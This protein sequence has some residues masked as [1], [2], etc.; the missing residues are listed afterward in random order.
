MFS[1]ILQCVI[2][3]FLYHIYI[4]ACGTPTCTYPPGS[5][6]CKT[7]NYT[8]VDCTHRQ[9]TCI[10]SLEQSPVQIESLD[11]SWNQISFVPDH[12]F[13]GLI[14]LL[15]LN[16][17][18]NNISTINSQTFSG[19]SKLRHLDLSDNTVTVVSGSPFQDLVS[20][21]KLILRYGETDGQLITATS[22]AGLENLQSLHITIYKLKNDL[23]APFAELQSLSDLYILEALLL[24]TEYC[25]TIDFTGLGNLKNLTLDA[26]A[27]FDICPLISL[28]KLVIATQTRLRNEC[29]NNVPLKSLDLGQN[30]L[31][32]AM[33]ERLSNLTSLSLSADDENFAHFLINRLRL[34]PSPLQSLKL[35]YSFYHSKLNSSYFRPIAWW[36][37]SLHVLEI[38]VNDLEMS[39]SPFQWFPKLQRLSIR[40]VWPNGGLLFDEN[41]FVGLENLQELNLTGN[42]GSTNLLQSGALQIF[43][44]YNSLRVLNL[45]N[46]GLTY[47]SYDNRTALHQICNIV[48]L[49]VLD[50]TRNSFGLLHWKG[51]FPNLETFYL[52]NQKES[53]QNELLCK[54]MPKVKEMNYASAF[55]T[56]DDYVACP[57]LEVLDLSDMSIDF[58]TTFPI[59]EAIVDVPSLKRLQLN[60]LDGAYYFP[61]L[62]ILTMFYAP[63][64]KV[65]SMRSNSISIVSDSDSKLLSKLTYLDMSDNDLTTVDGLQHLKSIVTLLLSGNMITSLP[66]WF[67]S[68]STYQYM[69][70]VELANNPYVCDCN[71]IPFSKWIIGNKVILLQVDGGF[72][73]YV[74]G[75]PDERK[76]ESLT[77]IELDCKSYLWVYIL[78]GV[79]GAIILTIILFVIAL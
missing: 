62:E 41:V 54:Y 33:Y 76:G 78:I 4:I 79:G 5:I 1:I 15:R 35:D 18:G 70:S 34:L 25:Y 8:N 68:P 22:F 36:N 21:Q 69:E 26:L 13:S 16:L 19:L 9:L 48:S 51:F 14:N 63:Q 23:I 32:S 56:F 6:S 65:L 7:W 53:Y 47:S 20:L 71:V 75:L 73:R 64:L 11:L 49:E 55:M 2:V 61:N 12:S 24:D 31:H 67:L 42:K 77:N 27:C 17:R 74:C 58:I 29:L 45:A 46:N 30:S 10:P 37:S 39:G 57:D 44:R 40:S 60:R 50:L 59:V 72:T 28:Q 52:Q 43:S 38:T 3:F 66:E